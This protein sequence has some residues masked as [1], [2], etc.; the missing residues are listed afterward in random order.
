MQRFVPS[1]SIF[2]MTALMLANPASAEPKPADV[3][4]YRHAV[5]ESMAANIEALSLIAF[6]KVDTT[7]L[8]QSHADALA[9]GTAE[10][11]NLFPAGTG[12]GDTHAL[13][14]I[15]ESPDDFMAGAATAEDA[16]AKLRDA[17]AG[18]D[19]KAIMGAFAAAGKTC[20]GC[21]EKYREEDDD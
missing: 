5:M 3:I 4:K 8:Y 15:W 7:A 10:I 18:G 9:S 20:K 11:K 17:V 2:L 21:H 6:N 19:N 12:E 13:P 16:F 14:A 1:A